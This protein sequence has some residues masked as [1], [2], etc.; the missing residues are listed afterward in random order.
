V[1]GCEILNGAGKQVAVA[2]ETILI[3][4]GRSW[5]RPVYV[6]DEVSAAAPGAEA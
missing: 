3:L 1:V 2:T 5:D 6:A 4:P